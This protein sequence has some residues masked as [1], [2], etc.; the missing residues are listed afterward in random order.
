MRFSC[1]LCGDCCTGSQVVRLTSGDLRLLGEKLGLASVK[2][3]R[4]RG[5]VSLVREPLGADRFVWRPR[6]RFRNKPFRQCPFLVNDVDEAGVYRG[7]CSLHPDFKPLICTLAPW[8]RDVEDPGSGPVTETWSV[9]APVEGCP[10]MGQGPELAPPHDLRP[11]LDQEVRWMRWLI[12]ESPRCPDE[13]A[14]WALVE[15]GLD[16]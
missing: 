6:I 3:L 14:A 9:V 1:T 13:D 8:S 15:E 11:R 4:T 5:L 10:G 16:R 7:L 12:A 2:D